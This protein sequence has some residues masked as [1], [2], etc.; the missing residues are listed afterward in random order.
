MHLTHFHVTRVFFCFRLFHFS[1]LHSLLIFSPLLFSLVLFVFSLTLQSPIHPFISHP[2]QL[3]S[4]F[5]CFPL[6]HLEAS[7]ALARP[8]FQKQQPIHLPKKL[9]EAMLITQKGPQERVQ[10]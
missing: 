3:F 4:G 1:P 10:A 9:A 7:S 8:L 5:C 2:S 6:S